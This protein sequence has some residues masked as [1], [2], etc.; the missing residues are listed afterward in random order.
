MYCGNFG[1]RVY[2]ISSKKLEA[3]YQI[4]L[5]KPIHFSQIENKAESEN[6]IIAFYEIIR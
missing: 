5:P 4:D 1:N 3:I 2:R 6:P